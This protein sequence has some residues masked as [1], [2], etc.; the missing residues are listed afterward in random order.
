MSEQNKNPNT[1]INWRT[2]C[3]KRGYL[4]GETIKCIGEKLLGDGTLA[5]CDNL[6]HGLRPSTLRLRPG[7]QQLPTPNDLPVIHDLVTADIQARLALGISRYGT[8]LQ[9][10]NGRDSLQDAYEEA[11]D[12][13][14]YLRQTIF[15]RDGK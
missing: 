3:D 5:K 6:I 4:N 2:L 9:P 7:D 11:L 14:T 8:G 13:C 1:D 15:E 12:M 10:H